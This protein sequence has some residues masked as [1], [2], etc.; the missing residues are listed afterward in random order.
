MTHPVIVG[1][2]AEQAAL[3]DRAG[4]WAAV[5]GPDIGAL[6]LVVFGS[7]ARGDFNQWSD[8]DVLVVVADPDEAIED[9]VWATRPGLVEPVVWP[10]EE[11]ARRRTKRDPIAGE[12]DTI[13]VTVFGALPP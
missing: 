8:I 9:K 12:A 3:I 6:A 13:G 4:Q 1:R 7:V 5:V 2:L 11:L 10:L